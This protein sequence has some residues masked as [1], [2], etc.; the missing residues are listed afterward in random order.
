MPARTKFIK[1]L[2][3]TDF[4]F[5]AELME[6]Y[7]STEIDFETVREWQLQDYYAEYSQKEPEG[8]EKLCKAI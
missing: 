2:I 1:V 5:K 3:Y 4:D 6:Q 7:L 8:P